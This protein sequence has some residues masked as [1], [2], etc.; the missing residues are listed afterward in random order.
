MFHKKSLVTLALALPLALALTSCGGD[1]TPTTVPAPTATTAA[2]AA[3]TDTTAPAADTP[4]TA[5]AADTATTAAS[6]GSTGGITG[7]S[8]LS[9]SVTFWTTY[10]TVSPEMDTFNNTIV[11]AFKKLYPNV[12]VNVQGFPDTDLRQKILTA[13]AGGQTP[14]LA[15]A[16]IVQVPEFAEIGA[17]AALDTEMSDFDTIKGTV[18]EGPLSSNFYKGHYYGL[19]LDTNTRVLIYNNEVFAKA[20]ITTPPTTFE[21]MK[22][23]CDKVKALGEAD[24][25]CYAEGGT[26]AW[27]IL[28]WI[29]SNGGDITDPTYSKATG[30]LNGAATVGAITMLKSM[31]DDKTLSPSILGNGIA[32]SDALG[33]AQSATILDGPWMVGIFASQ[34]PD[35]KIGFA[36]V[37][38]GPG[39]SVSVVGGEDIV[40]FEQSQNKPAAEAFMRYMLSNDPQLALGKVG[41]MPVLKSLSNNPDLPAYYSTFQTQL[42]TAKARTPSPSWSKIDDAINGAALQ[43]LKGEKTPQQAMDEAAATVDGL[44]AAK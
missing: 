2:A 26:G 17:L 27:S 30:Y 1:V 7:D 44:L 18:F 15:R 37:P 32:T 23:D 13:I 21:E 41:Q 36:P 28:P 22:A 34:F 5:M 42:A 11:P 35:L 20:G 33:K 9:G 38:A 16:D 25:Y 29:W 3:P 8:N 39:G 31:L 12:T 10:N 14:D 43:A 24:T 19:P 4:T 40:M 6:S